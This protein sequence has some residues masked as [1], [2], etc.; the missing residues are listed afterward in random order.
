MGTQGL[1]R[2]GRRPQGRG[3][4]LLAVAGATSLVTVLLAVPITVLAVLALVPQDQGHWVSG[5]N[6][7]QRATSCGCL[8]TYG[9]AFA[10]RAQLNALP[11]GNVWSVS[12]HS[13]GNPSLN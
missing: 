11:R 12:A 9:F 8:F 4:L 7:L 3:C 1:H 2:L 5:C 13:P 10:H 6:G